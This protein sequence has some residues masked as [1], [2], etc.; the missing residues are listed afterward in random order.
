MDVKTTF[1]NG[2]IEEEI[3]MDQLECFTSVGE[4]HKVCRLLKSIYSLKQAFRSW[5][6]CFDE[7]IWGCDFI[8]NEFDLCVYKKI[9]GSTVVYLVLYI[10]NIL[11]IGND[12]KMFGDIKA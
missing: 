6:T 4:E 12:V 3:A 7:V 9:S 8:K 5:N 11:L 2:F 1:L 10:H